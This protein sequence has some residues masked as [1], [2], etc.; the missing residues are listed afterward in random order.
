MVLTKFCG[1]CRVVLV[2]NITEVFFIYLSIIFFF[3]Q[4]QFGVV[5]KA[6]WTF[7]DPTSKKQTEVVFSFLLFFFTRV[8]YCKIWNYWSKPYCPFERDIQC[9]GINFRRLKYTVICTIACLQLYNF[10][11]FRV[12]ILSLFYFYFF[13]LMLL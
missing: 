13:R 10:I 5:Y 8:D 11:R 9:I 2:C 4:G 12:H 7:T 1:F 3:W 6:S